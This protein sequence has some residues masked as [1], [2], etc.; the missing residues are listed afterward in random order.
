MTE[1][2]VN[3]MFFTQVSQDVI[4]EEPEHVTTTPLS[5]MQGTRHFTRRDIN[6]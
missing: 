6:T 3:F 1:V 5:L 2:T 4:P